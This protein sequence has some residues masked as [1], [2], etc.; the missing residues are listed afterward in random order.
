MMRE[1]YNNDFDS[2]L[3]K[4]GNFGRAQLTI[5]LLSTYISAY[6]G[7]Q[8]YVPVFAGQKV[9]FYCQMNV[10]GE[11]QNSDFGEPLFEQGTSI[12]IRNLSV[13][14]GFLFLFRFNYTDP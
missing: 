11:V 7:W 14:F 3:E 1:A 4:A 10:S 9:D 13:H 8:A 12:F 2:N 6:S 5:F